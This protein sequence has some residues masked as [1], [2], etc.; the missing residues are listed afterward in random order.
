MLAI[1][2]QAG[3]G[4]DIDRLIAHA[5]QALPRFARPRYIDIV[6]ELPR[7]PT[8]KVKKAELRK[9][10]VTAATIDCRVRHIADAGR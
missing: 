10:G 4:I 6:E 7:T 1:L 9:R 8:S 3:Q 2:P 5:N